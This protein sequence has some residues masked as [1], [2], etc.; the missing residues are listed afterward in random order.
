MRNEEGAVSKPHLKIEQKAPGTP[1][2]HSFFAF[3]V[4]N[5]SVVSVTVWRRMAPKENGVSHR[6]W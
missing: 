3:A 5:S 4:L 6:F 2:S 1:F